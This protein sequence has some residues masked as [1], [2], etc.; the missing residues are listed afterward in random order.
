MTDILTVLLMRAETFVY[1][2]NSGDWN[3]NPFS[4]PTKN[5]GVWGSVCFGGVN[6]DNKDDIILGLSYIPYLVPA[7]WTD[8]EVMKG[9]NGESPSVLYL[10]K[11]Q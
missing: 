8:R 2:E 9:R 7:A 10:I 5:F 3:F 11:N 4:L 1:P 6:G